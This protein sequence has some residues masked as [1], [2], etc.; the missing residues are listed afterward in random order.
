MGNFAKWLPTFL[1]GLIMCLLSS[2]LFVAEKEQI[3]QG[4]QKHMPEALLYRFRLI[5]RSLV[6]AV[7]GYFKARIKIEV[8][9]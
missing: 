1:I 3:G 6:K 9:I 5:K 2:Y 4:V 7:G 8:W